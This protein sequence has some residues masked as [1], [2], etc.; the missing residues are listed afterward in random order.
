MADQPMEPG[1]ASALTADVGTT[2]RSLLQVDVPAAEAALR[3]EE[4]KKARLTAPSQWTVSNI[5]SRSSCHSS[6]D[7]TA[8]RQERATRSG[9]PHQSTNPIVCDR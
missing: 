8:G 7:F 5:R 3:E 4:A 6:A 9:G 2:R 1:T